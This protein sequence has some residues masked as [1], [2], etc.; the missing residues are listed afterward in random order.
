MM[1]TQRS[2][3]RTL[4]PALFKPNYQKIDACEAQSASAFLSRRLIIERKYL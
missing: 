4:R 3:S 1:D 2:F